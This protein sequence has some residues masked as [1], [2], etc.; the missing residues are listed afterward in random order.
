MTKYAVYDN[1]VFTGV[2]KDLP[3][4][5]VLPG[6]PY[7]KFYTLE[8]VDPAYDAEL[9]VKEGP[10]IEEDHVN[11]VRR[12]VYTVRNKTQPELDADN[13]AKVNALDM[14]AL[15][16]LFQ[17]ENRLRTLEGQNQITLNQFKNAVK[18]LINGN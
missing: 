5:P 14:V 6:K 16:I 1:Q 10:T 3:S 7:R 4:V 9:Q 8:L 11:F 15:R 17:H 13:D 18:A 2:I 12:T